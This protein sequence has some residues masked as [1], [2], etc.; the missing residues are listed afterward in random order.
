M[1]LL[2]IEI[3]YNFIVLILYWKIGIFTNLVELKLELK[4]VYLDLYKL[5]WFN[6]DLII[7]L[8]E[9]IFNFIGFLILIKFWI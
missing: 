6:D 2:K 5:N 4:I 7:I 3:S 1:N 8:L 9:L